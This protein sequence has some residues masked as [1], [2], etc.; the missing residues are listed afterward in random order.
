MQPGR[1]VLAVGSR[2]P[3]KNIETLVAAIQ[4][5]GDRGLP[6][7]LAGGSNSRVFSQATALT[8]SVQS[9][10]YL[11]DGELRA[12]YEQAQCFAL[13]SL[14]EGFGLPPLEAMR[15]GCPVVVSRA[16]ALPEVCGDGALYADANDADDWLRCLRKL[17][18]TT[19]R[20]ELRQRGRAQAQRFSWERASDVLLRLIGELKAA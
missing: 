12:L 9:A 8:S 4:R 17:Q 1:Y 18:D 5:W 11:T 2:S 15:C 13:P 6:L 7:V 10:G 14:Y 16:A 19:F 20:E 3:H